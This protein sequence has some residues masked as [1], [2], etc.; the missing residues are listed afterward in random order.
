MEPEEPDFFTDDLSH[1]LLSGHSDSFSKYYYEP[2]SG[3]LFK[4][5]ATEQEEENQPQLQQCLWNN[6]T[7]VISSTITISN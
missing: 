7:L 4:V 6:S 5:I 3:Y 2:D 1:V